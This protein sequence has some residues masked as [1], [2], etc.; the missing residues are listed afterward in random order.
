MEH[1]WRTRLLQYGITLAVGLLIAGLVA[2]YRGFAFGADAAWN[3]RYLSD[4]CFVS[5][6]LLC[7]VGGLVLISTATDFFDMISY[8]F[9]SLLVLFT[10]LRKPSE[11]QSFFDY[12]TE[13]A[14]RRTK[15]Q[16]FL[17]A[18]G[19]V[20]LAASFAFLGLYYALLG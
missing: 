5:T 7:G 10:P 13:R 18:V 1:K 14:A 16:P 8:G 4:G 3:M 19:L 12:K 11:H 6:V 2:C 20:F 17:L 15:A 9:K